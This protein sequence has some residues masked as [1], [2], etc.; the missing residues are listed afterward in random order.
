[1]QKKSQISE[2]EL[3]TKYQIKLLEKIRVGFGAAW[4]HRK[5]PDPPEDPDIQ[6]YA[7]QPNPNLVK[8]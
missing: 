1:L 8:L 7:S 2:K 5:Y 3:L 4:D 6:S